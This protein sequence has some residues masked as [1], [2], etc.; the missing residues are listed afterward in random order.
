[1]VEVLPKVPKITTFYKAPPEV[2]LKALLAHL[3]YA[4]L[5]S[6]NK[7]PV[8]ISL[9]LD[10]EQKERLL[11]LLRKREQAI[12]WKLADIKGINPSFCTHKINLEED[13]KLVVQPQR[14]LNPA[15]REVV[16]KE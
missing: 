11:T 2:K 4:F 9:K 6:N 15:M 10:N 13:S 1:M 3:E 14:T 16:K 8:I 7:L 5:R 12:I